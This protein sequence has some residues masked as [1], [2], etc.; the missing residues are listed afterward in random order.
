MPSSLLMSPSVES[1]KKSAAVARAVKGIAVRL[2]HDEPPKEVRVSHMVGLTIRSL[3]ITKRV[4]EEAH[5]DRD[6]RC[7]RHRHC[8]QRLGCAA[9]HR[10]HRMAAKVRQ[11]LP[12]VLTFAFRW[13]IIDIREQTF[14]S[15]ESDKQQSWRG[16]IHTCVSHPV[17]PVADFA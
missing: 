3:V 2:F 7:C 11:E 8:L 9:G 16:S 12:V 4:L 5:E 1:K 6:Q 17:R 14:T 10:K 13:A 15:Y